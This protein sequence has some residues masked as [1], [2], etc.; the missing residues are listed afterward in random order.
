MMDPIFVKLALAAKFLTLRIWRQRYQEDL[1]SI[2]AEQR[3]DPITGQST[4]FIPWASNYYK[5]C[6]EYLNDRG[7]C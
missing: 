5:N 4:K 7:L 6:L 1:Y 3:N 2:W